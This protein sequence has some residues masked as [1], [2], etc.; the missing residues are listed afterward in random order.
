MGK[1]VVYGTLRKGFGNYKWHL[2][3]EESKFLGEVKLDGYTMVSLGGFPAI[4]PEELLEKPNKD[5]R[6][7]GEVFEVSDEVEKSCDR[8]EGYSPERY[9]YNKVKVDTPYG[10]AYVYVQ[11][12]GEY[13][14]HE[15]VESGDWKQ[16]IVKK[17]NEKAK[18]NQST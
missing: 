12:R 9:W 5:Y 11:D 10:E 15:I 14:E 17:Y 18:I 3:N 13:L 1:I 16:Y 2:E 7:V 8:L 6:I 4:I